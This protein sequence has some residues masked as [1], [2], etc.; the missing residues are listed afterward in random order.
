MWVLDAHG[1]LSIF[2][3]T[4]LFQNHLKFTINNYLKCVNV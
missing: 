3:Q 2:I 4:L 1:V